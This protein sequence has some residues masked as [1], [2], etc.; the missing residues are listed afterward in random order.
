M[1]VSVGVL[2]FLARLLIFGLVTLGVSLAFSPIQNALL[3]FIGG[4][5]IGGATPVRLT[6]AAER[7]RSRP[8]RRRP[9][10]ATSFRAGT[11]D[12]GD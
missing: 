2:Q 1:T 8:A 7:A 4:L 9:T 5:G 6:L 12:A 11:A 3:Q 10:G